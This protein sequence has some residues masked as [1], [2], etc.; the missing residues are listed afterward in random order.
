MVSSKGKIELKVIPEKSLC[1]LCDT[2]LPR[3]PI[4]GQGEDADKVFCCTGCFHVYNLLKETGVGKENYKESS[5][6]QI[7]EKLGI[8]QNTEAVPESEINETL[9]EN[10]T[11]S[12]NLMEIVLQLEGVWCSSCTWIIEKVLSEH[13]GVHKI[14]VSFSTDTATINYNPIKTSKN[15]IIAVINKLGYGAT[16]RGSLKEKGENEISNLLVKGG[17]SFFLFMNI[18]YFSSVLY[19]GYFEKLTGPIT[20]IAPLILLMLAAPSVFWSGSVIHKMAYYSIKNR[21]MAME[22]LLSMSILSSFFFS[23]YSVIMGYQ[24]VYFDTSTGLVTLMLT[25]KLIE[26]SAKQKAMENINSLYQMI[27]GK[28]RIKKEDGYSLVSIK[29]VKVDD[30]YLVKE[31]EKIPAD[32]IIESG[33]TTVDESMLTGESTPVMK[34]VGDAVYGSSINYE[35]AIEA[36]VISIG[37]DSVISRIIKMVEASFAKK[38]KIEEIVNRFTRYFI[39]GVLLI[40]IVTFIVIF[41][42]S[43]LFENALLRG[44]T[45][46]VV[47]CPCALGIATPLAILFGIGRA[48]REGMLVRDGS[49]L[50]HMGKINTMVFDKTGTIT[51]G[52]MYVKDFYCPKLTKDDI[53]SIASIESYS[54]HSIGKAIVKYCEEKELP[55]YKIKNVKSFPGM[56]IRGNVIKK[57]KTRK[58]KLGNIR[59]LKKSKV[60]IPDEIISQGDREEEAGSTVVYFSIDNKKFGYI[61]LMDTLKKNTRKVIESLK[62]MG[63]SVMLLSGDSEKTTSKVAELAGIPEY[64]AEFIPEEKL[65]VIEDLKKSGSNTAMVGDGVNDAPALAQADTGIAMGSG[66]EI[67]IESSDVVMM[68]NDLSLIPKVIKISKF[69]IKVIKLNLVWAFIYNVLGVFL[70]IQGVLNPLLAAFAMVLSSLSVTGNSLR[71]RRMKLND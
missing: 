44:I 54:N 14:S 47:A 37:G 23:V 5:L 46:L 64:K 30:I 68:R 58:V 17:V 1:T 35:S 31:G 48:S 40:S 52:T 26:A 51:E 34:R 8:L 11:E 65:T 50:Q 28:A 70:A 29:E 36:K 21:N 16:M 56:G 19:V 69:A 43:G 59:Y 12:E 25:G 6:F 18:M 3:K 41:I 2:P 71:I 4:R 55:L 27:P 33:N 7:S 62:S 49:V 67:A 63:I 53:S 39:P 60:K 38:S 66:T 57:G 24:H 13:P 42:N 15:S 32:G 22:L 20:K 9:L 45:V 61:A 10:L